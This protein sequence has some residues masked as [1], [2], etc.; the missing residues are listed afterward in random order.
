MNGN[1]GSDEKIS[2]TS[3]TV[4]LNLIQDDESNYT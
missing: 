1:A 3:S 4:E 2:D